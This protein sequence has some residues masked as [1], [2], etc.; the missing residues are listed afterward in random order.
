MAIIDADAHVIETERTWQYMDR[1]EAQYRPRIVRT[2]N[3]LGVETAWWLIDGR[4]HSM[5][6]NI[7]HETP[8]ESREMADIAARLRHM[9]ELGVDVQVLYPSVFLR[10]LTEKPAADLALARSY[11]RWLADIW[12]QAK[13]R[14]LWAAVLPLLDMEA[15]LAELR[16]AKDHGA[17]AVFVRGVEGTRKLSDPYFFP[18]Y[19][20]ASE[21]DL[22]ICPHSGNGSFEVHD[23]FGA[24]EPGFSKFKLVTIGAFHTFIWNDIPGRFPRLRIGFIEVSSQWVPYVI[25]DV[26][27]RLKRRGRDLGNNVLADN[28]IWVA[29]QTD[30][31]LPYVLQYTGPDHVVIGSDYGH[32]DT[33]S[34]IHALRTLREQGTVEP[35]VIDRILDAN[36]R[37]LYAL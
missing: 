6:T 32:N 9:D 3:A 11:N 21:M 2:E 1:S 29:C 30:D 15:S 8:T 24:D 7:G 20:A 10:P 35:G 12:A 33:S 28:R 25:H 13:G 23:Y 22:P 4:I 26:S 18:L 5:Q 19:E 36:A 27:R 16:W 14:L 34:E 17:C 37:A 31:D